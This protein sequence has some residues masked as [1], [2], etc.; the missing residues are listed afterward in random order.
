MKKIMCL[1]FVSLLFG[2]GGVVAVVATP[3]IAIQLR[4]ML[5]LTKVL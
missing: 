5:A 1:L 3:K 2:C 4:L